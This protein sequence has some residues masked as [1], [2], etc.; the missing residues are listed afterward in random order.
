M[1]GYKEVLTKFNKFRETYVYAPNLETIRFTNRKGANQPDSSDESWEVLD[2]AGYCT[3][4]CIT[5]HKYKFL[6]VDSNLHN[7]AKG[8]VP[9]GFANW[10]DMDYTQNADNKEYMA[11]V[12]KE[13]FD[14]HTHMLRRS[15]T[16]TNTDPQ[17]PLARK[18]QVIV[19]TVAVM[20]RAKTL[21]ES[22]FVST[23]LMEEP[24]FNLLSLSRQSDMD[25]EER[26]RLTLLKIGKL[27]AGNLHSK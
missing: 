16:K 25:D 15:I 22:T 9:A 23:I 1:K 6:Q 19:I 8:E 17:V 4:T 5:D 3:Y 13:V 14:G 20:R 26:Q 11:Q 24:W 27:F 18:E 21:E 10:A 7:Y 2:R 12:C